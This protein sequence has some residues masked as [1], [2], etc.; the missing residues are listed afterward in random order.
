MKTY[1]IVFITHL[2]AFYK[3]NLYNRISEKKRIFVIFISDLSSIRNTDFTNVKMSFEHIFLNKGNFESRNVIFSCIKLIKM[4][5]SFSSSKIIVGGWD[6]P[7][8]WVTVFLKKHLNNAVIIESTIYE[9]K[10]SKVKSYIKRIFLS[11]V[12]TAYCSGTPHSELLKELKWRGHIYITHGVGLSNFSH[13]NSFPEKKIN[14][15]IKRF[16]YVGRLSEEKGLLFLLDFFKDR[17]DLN[18]TIVG[19]GPQRNILESNASNNVFFL[20]FIDNIKLRD[21]YLSHDIFVLPSHSEPWG[22]VVEEALFFNLPIVCSSNV[23]CNVEL[24]RI[25]QTGTVFKDSDLVSFA[26]AVLK[27]ESDYSMF[28]ENIKLFNKENKDIRQVDT[29]LL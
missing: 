14:K 11:R 8:F 19:E 26:E 12:S 15:N 22:L 25:P 28:I 23:G 24:V 4:L 18:L 29:Y 17:K 3:I 13:R 27:I 16:L 7:E 10:L 6:L 21:V 2:P 5:Y 1:D 20:G 9:S